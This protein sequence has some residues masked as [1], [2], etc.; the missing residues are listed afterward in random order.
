M[1]TSVIEAIQNGVWDFEPT[2]PKQDDFNST[3]A[4][5]GTEEKVRVLAERLENGQPLW[6]PLDQ[7]TVVSE[8]SSPA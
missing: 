1:P 3:C 7:I 8:E 4:L 5:P 2:E 6:H